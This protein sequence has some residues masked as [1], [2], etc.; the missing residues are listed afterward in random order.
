MPFNVNSLVS[1]LNRTGVAHSSHFEV[2]VTGPGE[3]GVEES[4]MMRADTVDLP[5][6]TAQVA[7]YRVYGPIR[8]V[9]YGG[10]YTDVSCTIILSEDMREREYFELWHDKIMGTGVFKTGGNGKYNPSY[11]DEFTGTVT[12]RQYGSAGNV[13]SIYTLNEAYPLSIAAV[14]MSWAGAEVAKQ[15]IAFAYRDHKCVFNRSDQGRAGASFGLSIGT[16][17]ISGSLNIPGFGNVS[18]QNGLSNLVGAIKSPFG[19]IR[20]L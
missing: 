10:V 16:G 2:Q 15:T 9:P 14:Q 17:G 20:K 3:I 1:S 11:Y 5:S 13:S 12:I 19:L 18:A 4:I 8:K 7:E 6:R